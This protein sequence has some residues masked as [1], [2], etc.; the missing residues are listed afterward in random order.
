MRVRV[1]GQGSLNFAYPLALSLLGVGASA[2]VAHGA[3]AS[4]AA[5][6][7]GEVKSEVRCEVEGER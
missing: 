5:G 7:L 4:G 1:H 2:A 6:P 3:V